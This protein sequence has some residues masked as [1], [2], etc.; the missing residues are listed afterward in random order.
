MWSARLRLAISSVAAC[1]SQVDRPRRVTHGPA[2]VEPHDAK[3]QKELGSSAMRKL[4]SKAI[5]VG[6]A[7]ETD[8]L[9]HCSEPAVAR[10]LT[11]S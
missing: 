1:S 4:G 11:L 6:L 8:E 5:A 3:N 9:K 10:S 7:V 2:V